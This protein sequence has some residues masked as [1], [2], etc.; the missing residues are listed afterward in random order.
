MVLRAFVIGLTV[1]CF[2]LNHLRFILVNRTTIEHVLRQKE[3]VRV[4][5]D[6]SGVH[7]QVM[8]VDH[9]ERLWDLGK[10]KN[11]KIIMGDSAIEWFCKYKRSN[12]HTFYSVD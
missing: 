12:F 7:Y 2:G 11:W 8:E 4:D 1:S 10:M 9:P 3:H 5:F 6:S